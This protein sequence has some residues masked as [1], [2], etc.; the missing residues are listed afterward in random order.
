MFFSPH[1]HPH[2]P[3][4]PP[5][6]EPPAARCLR[7]TDYLAKPFAAFTAETLGEMEEHYGIIEHVAQVVNVLGD[8]AGAGHLR[9]VRQLSFKYGEVVGEMLF[10]LASASR[11]GVWVADIVNVRCLVAANHRRYDGG[12]LKRPQLVLVKESRRE[13]EPLLSKQAA[14]DKFVACYPWPAVVEVAKED[15]LVVVH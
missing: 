7:P 12:Y 13:P 15:A 4:I 3:C 10:P 5:R 8:I 6:R 11:Y 1:H 14:P 2:H 9:Y